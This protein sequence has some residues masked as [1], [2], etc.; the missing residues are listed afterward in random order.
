MS[1]LPNIDSSWTL[2]LDRDGVVNQKLP[3]DYV[4][5]EEEFSF[6][7]GVQEAI[8]YLSIVFDRIIIVT[9][10][11]GIGKGIMSEDDLEAVHAHMLEEINDTGGRIDE[12]YYATA[13]AAEQHP[14]RKP[15]IGM[16]EKSREDFK[17]IV[18][19]HCIIVGDSDS[20]MEFGHNAGM[21]KVRIGTAEGASFPADHYFE[22]LSA[23]TEAL[24]QSLGA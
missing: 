14:D 15:G 12:I 1:Q 13:V 3:N 24:R 22:S 10:Q 5:N 20:D 7:P 8:A 19:E 21:V 23:F 4:K 2:Y 18:P 11:Q 6:L 17:E 16:A 9:N